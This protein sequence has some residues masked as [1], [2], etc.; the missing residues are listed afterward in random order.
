MACLTLK[1][2]IPL[3]LKHQNQVAFL[4]NQT[5][6]EHYDVII[7]GGGLVGTTLACSLA[8]NSK[9]AG[10]KVL[11]LEGAPKFQRANLDGKFS[12]TNLLDFYV[13][14]YFTKNNFKFFFITRLQ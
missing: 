1:R 6:N 8:R 13:A 9:L 4:C 5:T 3:L 12:R 10:R 11:L 7:A 14:F 2:S